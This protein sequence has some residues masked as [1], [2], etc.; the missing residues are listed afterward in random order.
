MFSSP[1]MSAEYLRL[2]PD[3]ETYADRPIVIDRK[4]DPDT[5]QS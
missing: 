1:L 4:E 5:G 2:L 3:Y